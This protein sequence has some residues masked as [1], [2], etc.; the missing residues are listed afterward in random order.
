VPVGG[1]T[2]FLVDGWQNYQNPRQQNRILTLSR[3]QIEPFWS[4]REAN[5]S[6][7]LRYEEQ[8]VIASTQNSVEPRWGRYRVLWILRSFTAVNLIS[9]APLST[10]RFIGPK[11]RKSMLNPP[12]SCRTTASKISASLGH[13]FRLRISVANCSGDMGVDFDE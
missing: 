9:P 7:N 2:E 5:R 4:L 1:S 10:S 13:T 12:A 3:H 6:P 11:R 8:I